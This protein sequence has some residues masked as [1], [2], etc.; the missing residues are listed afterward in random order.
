MRF[1]LI[2]AVWLVTLHCVYVICDNIVCCL[3]NVAGDPSLAS[4]M[5]LNEMGTSCLL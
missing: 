4:A 2:C 3:F 5:L 1:V